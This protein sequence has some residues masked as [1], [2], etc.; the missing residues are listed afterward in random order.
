MFSFDRETMTMVAV[1]VS[2]AAIYYIYQD[3]QKM[4]KDIT[5]C[6]DVSFGL[7]HKLAAAQAPKRVAEPAPTVEESED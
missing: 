5:E 4:K 7:V 3:S 6:K 1:I 2:L